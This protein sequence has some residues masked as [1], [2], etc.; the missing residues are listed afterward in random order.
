MHCQ[1]GGE[2]W[3]WNG[4]LHAFRRFPS[5]F[6]LF[7]SSGSFPGG[8]CLT[9]EGHRYDRCSSQVLG[10]LVHQFDRWG[11]PVWSVRAELMQ[12]LCF[13]WWFACIFPGGVAL[14]QGELACVQ[15]ELFLVF[16]LWLVICALCLS[17]GLSRMCRAVA[18]ALGVRDLSYLGD[19]SL[20]LCLA[21]DRLLEFL[22]ICFFSFSFLL[23]YYLWVLSMH[24]S[25][26]RLRTM[27]GSRTGGWSLPGVMSDWQRCVDWFLA[28]YYKCRLRL[29][30][31]W[32]RWRTS[33]KG[34]CWRW[35]SVN[36]EYLLYIGFDYDLQLTRH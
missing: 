1:Q 6:E 15:G 35:I 8:A 31:C 26:G 23:C 30:W 28:K 20:C 7:L 19:L 9:G 27:C 14:V 16:K 32:C 36:L 3:A 12:L 2:V 25:R 17:I 13:F 18:L 5:G 29:D 34:H 21:F 10:D 33:V 24:S 22:F 4:L 11:W